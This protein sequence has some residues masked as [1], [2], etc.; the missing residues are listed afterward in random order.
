MKIGCCSYKS[1]LFFRETLFFRRLKTSDY[2]IE[3]DA[4]LLIKLLKVYKVVTYNM[5]INAAAIFLQH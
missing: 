4:L 2:L 1:G 5:H 3:Y